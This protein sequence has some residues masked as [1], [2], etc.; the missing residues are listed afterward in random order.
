MQVDFDGIA[1]LLSA[2]GAFVVSVVTVG[3]QFISW[4][5]ARIAREEQESHKQKLDAIACDVA[6]IRKADS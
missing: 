4:R 5:D 3:M 2:F 1:T 6:S